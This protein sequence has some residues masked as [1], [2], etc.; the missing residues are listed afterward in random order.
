MEADLYFLVDSSWSIGEENFGNVRQF[1][2]SLTQSVHQVGGE[3]FKFALVTYTQQLPNNTGSPG[4][5]QGHAVPWGGTRTGFGQDYLI[6]TQLTSASGSRAADGA[7][8]VV[9]VL[10]EGLSQDY[11]AEPAQVLRL[12]G[13]EVLA[14]GVQDSVDSELREMGSQPH[15]THI[16]SVD[17]FMTL[18]NII[19]DLVV[20]LC[21]A[22]TCSGGG[23]VLW[24][25]RPPWLEEGQVMK[26]DQC[27]YHY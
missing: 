24:Q 22:V 26:W 17:T 2:C 16:F 27:H 23:G 1:V 5:R 20:G 4:T 9:V 11:V 21:D 6:R 25:T 13:V 15:N 19:Q 8:K 12:A 3:R 10:T 14:V 18:R 7:S